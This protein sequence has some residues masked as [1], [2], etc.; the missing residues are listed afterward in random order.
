M[1]KRGPCARDSSDHLSNEP[2]GFDEI[3]REEVVQLREMLEH[4]Q[5]KLV[6]RESRRRRATLTFNDI[7]GSERTSRRDSRRWRVY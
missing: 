5:M 2:K 7:D 4:V 6:S 1:S 3:R